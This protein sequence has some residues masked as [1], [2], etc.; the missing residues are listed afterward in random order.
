[1]KQ[2]K[3]EQVKQTLSLLADVLVKLGVDGYILAA[4]FEDNGDL[5]IQG[6]STGN[7]VVL[8]HTFMGVKEKLINDTAMEHVRYH[9][10]AD[11]LA[12]LDEKE[13]RN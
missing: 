7:D 1:M 5:S 13:G 9:E 8:A 2:E 3:V 4:S 11:F 6:F 12:L 10:M